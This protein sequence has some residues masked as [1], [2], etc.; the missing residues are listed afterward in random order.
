MTLV[1]LVNGHLCDAN[2]PIFSLVWQG[3]TFTNQPFENCDYI[4][5]SNTIPR[6]I[7]VNCPKENVW[8]L[9]HEPPTKK[10]NRWFRRAY[11]HCYRVYTSDTSLTGKN[12]VYS[13]AV[14]SW[15]VDKSYDFLA[16]CPIPD[17]PKPLSWVTSSLK[18]IPGHRRRMNFLEKLQSSVQFDL[19]GRGFSPIADKWDGIAPYRYSLAVENHSAPHYWTEKIADCFLS[20][21]M[22]IYYGCTNISSYFPPESYISIDI[23]QPEEAIEIIK[24]AIA[25]DYWLRHRDAIVHAR[26]LVLNQYQIFPFIA[27]NIRE[28][29]AKQI[30]GASQRIYLPE[31]KKSSLEVL[32]VTLLEQ[33]IA[34]G[35]RTLPVPV[36]NSL[37]NNIGAR[38]HPHH[39]DGD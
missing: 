30:P 20:Y 11:K 34:V 25:S 18:S 1:R 37:W 23:N 24:E 36:R 27:N 28:H 31:T 29:E 22:P 19:W 38:L 21:T 10:L 5:F 2:A 9:M 7:V 13:H 16:T 33:T 3:I 39:E 15:L 4:V 35:Q 12:I 6:D 17:K 26:E 32:M 8:L 14:T